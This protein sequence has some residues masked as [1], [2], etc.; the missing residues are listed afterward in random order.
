MATKGELG[1]G[2]VTSFAGSNVI[3]ANLLGGDEVVATTNLTG[4]SVNIVVSSTAPVNG[5]GRSDGTIYI[6]TV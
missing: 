2:T 5:D 3:G 4:G 6:Q 1:A